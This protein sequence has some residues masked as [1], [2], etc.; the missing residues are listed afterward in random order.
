[1]IQL[2]DEF[3]AAKDDPNQL[4]ID[5]EVM[6]RLKLIHP[7]TMNEHRLPE[8][9]VAW[10]IVIPT[11][12]ETMDLFLVP[13]GWIPKGSMSEKQL[14]ERTTTGQSFT[15]AYLCSALVLPEVR[16]Q[17]LAQR[18]LIES[19]RSMQRDHPLKQLYCWTF[20]EEGKMLAK[21]VVR[22]LQLPLFE[23]WKK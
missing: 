14:F 17:G 1:M 3:F 21:A 2:A 6:A 19:I 7:A 9:P 5:E 16:R 22:E 23:R 12:Q 8:G 11:T 13:K 20:S 15:A 18:L 10:T 4:S